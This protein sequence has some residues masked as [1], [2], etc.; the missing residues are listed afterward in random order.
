MNSVI[1]SSLLGGI[2]AVDYRSSL[3]LMI[4]QP[5]CGGAIAGLVLG[6]PYNGLLAGTLLQVI[7]LGHIAIRGGKTPDLPLGGVVASS[8]Y[9][10][11]GRKLGGDQSLEG[12]VLFWSIFISVMKAVAG[13][14]FYELWERR[15]AALTDKAFDYARRGSLRRAS[16]IHLSMLFFHFLFGV[17]VL[18][19]VLP[20]GGVFVKYA[21]LGSESWAGHSPGAFRILLPFIGVGSLVRMHKTKPHLFWFGSGFFVT[22]IFLIFGGF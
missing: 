14:I 5:I 12:L 1:A 22:M 10:T 18:L 4:S 20:A 9:I 16:A 3:R 15:S 21:A 17:I 2:L 19:I 11:V 7:F 13:Q 6:D 8:L